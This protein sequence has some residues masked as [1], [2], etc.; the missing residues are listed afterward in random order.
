[1]RTYK[2]HYEYCRSLYSSDNTSK[3]NSVYDL[4]VDT[5]FLN[6]VTTPEYYN[7]IKKIRSAI[8]NKISNDVRKT[9]WPYEENNN[10][11]DSFID[12]MDML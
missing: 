5:D 10:P 9:D 12:R 2:E 3:Y 1:M 7:L 8:S 6:E 4:R 11:P